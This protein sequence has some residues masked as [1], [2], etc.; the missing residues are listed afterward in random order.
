MVFF[1]FKYWE[2]IFLLILH[3]F[4]KPVF[5]LNKSVCSAKINSDYKN[6][7]NLNTKKPESTLT[8]VS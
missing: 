6:C 1:N 3:A 4:E 2:G 7:V 5:G 8:E